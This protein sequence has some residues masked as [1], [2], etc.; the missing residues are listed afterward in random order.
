M[1]GERRQDIKGFENA[2]KDAAKTL[3]AAR[4]V[5]VVGHI[6]A[7]GI[8][9]SS[10]ASAALKRAGIEHSVRFVKKLDDAEIA[11]AKE[12]PAERIWFVDLGSGAFSK[13][14]KD[15]AV[16]SDHHRPDLG[17]ASGQADL[18]SFCGFHVNPHLFG[19]DGSTEIS[20]AGATYIVAKAM[21]PTNRD[22]AALAVVGATGDFQDAAEGALV[23]YNRRIL[24]DAVSAGLVRA[25]KDIRLFGRETRPLHA[26]LQY[27]AEPSLMPFIA[28]GR[29]RSRNHELQEDDAAR[30]E[31][32]MACIDFLTELGV[33]IKV[34]GHFRT[35]S[36][37]SRE[38]KQ[39]IVSALIN[40]MLDAGKGIVFIRRLIGEA[41]TLSKDLPGTPKDWQ[42]P[43]DGGVPCE[44]T[45]GSS[46]R[47]NMRALF[48]A[49]EYATLLNAC[50][51]HDRPEV[52]KAVCLGDRNDFLSE[53]I[54][55]QD[56]HREKLR[57]AIDL[58]KSNPVFRPTVV[59]A[60]G[61]S[62]RNIRYFHGQDRIEDTIVGIV[63]GM[64]LGSADI[65]SDRAII[66]FAQAMDGTCTLK[67][68]GRG[69]RDLTRQ[70]LDLSIAM[71]QASESVGGTGGGHNIAAG[72]SIPEG[73]EEEFLLAI[74]E[75]IGRQLSP[76]P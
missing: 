35:W 39:R 59:T 36:D 14:D 7:D 16:V 32:K 62:L 68:S 22:L 8:T 76:A 70:G 19:L 65:P 34:D 71:K 20:G 30:D 74:D 23:G 72:A 44:L 33:P 43:A 69:T 40:R 42:M 25:E 75:I 47:P 13:L 55:Q 21:D 53:A 54:R 67:V 12:H 10:I 51:R 66:A 2:A 48:D 9:A 17:N 41:Y 1:D 15:R 11:R 57:A 5:L 46:W 63:A 58:V 61:S 60:Q 29:P 6:D 50:G 64:L 52:G 27:S 31:D 45:D 24:D 18:G 38:E 73:K 49:K 3:L 26:F 37:L 4:S 56:N 28:G